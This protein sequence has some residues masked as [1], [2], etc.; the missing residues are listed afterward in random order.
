M[1][2]RVDETTVVGGESGLIS[3]P[4]PTALWVVSPPQASSPAEFSRA[5]CHGLAQRLSLRFFERHQLASCSAA[6]N[7]ACTPREDRA[8]FLSIRVRRIH[9]CAG[10]RRYLRY[11][12]KAAGE[13]PGFLPR[14]PN[15]PGQWN[16]SKT[17][18]GEPL[19]APAST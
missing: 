19:H 2:I 14:H 9:L 8:R 12:C 15:R 17:A 10:S 5:T 4:S 18:I 13:D 1:Y 7:Q 16:R 3:S 6:H 11:L